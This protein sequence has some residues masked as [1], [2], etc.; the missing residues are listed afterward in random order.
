MKALSIRAPWWWY[1]LY[2]GKDIENRDWPTHV[3]GRV[4]IHAS[5]W[6]R[7]EEIRDAFDEAS[8][9]WASSSPRFALP[10]VT[11]AEMKNLGGC[12]VGSVEIVDC[13][14]QSK[15]QWFVGDYGFMLRDPVVFKNPI[16]HKGALGFFGVPDDLVRGQI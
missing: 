7:A 12:L 4:L 13:V 5:K 2:A 8:Y 9:M 6:F 1:I 3:R 14:A 16:P 10:Q 15:S 11:L